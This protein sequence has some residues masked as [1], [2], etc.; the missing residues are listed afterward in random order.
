MANYIYDPDTDELVLIDS[1]K[2][3][4]L[5]KQARAKA[6]AVVQSAGSEMSG[7]GV[8][9]KPM[10]APDPNRTNII[11]DRSTGP[12]GPT[13]SPTGAT[14]TLANS[15][16]FYDSKRA[17]GYGMDATGNQYRGAGNAADPLTINGNPFTGTWQGKTYQNGILSIVTSATGPT[18]SPTGSSTIYTAP[19]GRI[20]T[21]INAY[22]T[23]INKTETD[24]KT[25]AG[26]SA[27]DI[28]FN[29]FNKNGLGSLIEPLKEFIVQGFS[30]DELTLKLRESK[31]YQDRFKANEFRIKNGFA[32]I[33]EATYLGLED[34]YQSIMQN[35]G[36]PASY[37]ERGA[38]GKQA[39]FENLIGGNVDP[40]TL[41]ERI[42]EGQKVLKGS[43]EIKDAISQFYPDV[44]N[45]DILAYV[46]DTKNAL[47]EIKRKVSAAE[48][49]G[50]ALK[51]TG[52]T[53]NR[54]RAEQLAS[55]GI[56]KQMAE[57]GYGTIGGGLQR[58]SELASMYGQP[59]YDQKTAEQ[60]VFNLAGGTEAAR[61]RR[62][63]TGLEKATFGGTTGMSSSALSRERAGQY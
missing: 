57:Q 41:E 27:Y 11:E 52:L 32:A 53:T 23:Y 2:G 4:L 63:L 58:G 16:S 13:G 51:Q 45:G 10:G 49:G 28:L 55:Y 62:K 54:A 46:L 6:N 59:A 26:Q 47:S 8:S 34:K 3:K 33:D 37:Y 60:E 31:Q 42:M 17:A 24:K 36:L 1:T 18:G 20:F 29:E 25:R 40:V 35:Y 9:S 38:L 7:G 44:T 14:T 50:A 39:G 61:E 19:D 30:K 48:I 43:K 21:D 22:N 15:D 56:T 12:T 5:V